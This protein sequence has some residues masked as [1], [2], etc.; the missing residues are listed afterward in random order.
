MA[1][2]KRRI[3]QN[4]MEEQS[5]T[6]V[7]ELLPHEWVIHQYAPD[8]G[9][10]IV[11]ET[12][13]YIDDMQTMAETLGEFF[14]VQLKSTH[15]ACYRTLK[16]QDRANVEKKIESYHQETDV[17]V[18][19]YPL[20][21]DEL[22]TV[23]SMGTA[24]PVVLFVAD[25]NTNKVYFICLNDYIEKILI[26]KNGRFKNESAVTLYIPTSNDISSPI[27]QNQLKFLAKRSKLFGA[28]NKFNYQ[29]SELYYDSS[30][31]TILR[32]I[33]INKNFDF[34]E[35]SLKWPPLEGMYEK[36]LEIESFYQSSWD[37]RIELILNDDL[38]RGLIWDEIIHN[39]LEN[40]LTDEDY[41]EILEIYFKFIVMSYWEKLCNLGR[42]YEDICKEWF[43]P[44][45][46]WN[47]F[48]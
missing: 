30:S 17:E 19:A 28:F 9:I 23:M 42:L 5:L 8:Y 13:E 45:Y 24:V 14:F 18:L 41:L 33:E 22:Y 44:T 10:D 3:L 21:I 25:M 12:F 29:K 34:W 36:M 16:I 43:L 46:F 20:E 7:R 11:I 38:L 40:K 1:H 48:Y 39:A 47:E 32:F 2:K 15:C 37:K 31:D 27:V 26:P 4:I 35:S 6:L